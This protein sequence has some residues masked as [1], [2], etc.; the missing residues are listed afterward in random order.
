MAVGV[1]GALTTFSRF[2]VDACQLW[3]I[4]GVMMAGAYVALSVVLSL[5][6]FW[7]MFVAVR[8]SGI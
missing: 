1:R 4:K 5:T 8:D 7:A 6:A 3:Q 2:T